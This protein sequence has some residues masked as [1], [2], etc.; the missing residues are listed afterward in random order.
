M[1]NR[2]INI[3]L[4]LAVVFGFTACETVDFG[5]T[6][7][8]P[9]N[10]AQP[11]P[12]GL[13]TSAER[14]LSGTIAATVP[15]MYVQYISNGQYPDESRYSG[16]NFGWAGYYGNL[17]DLQYVMENGTANQQ[18][19]ATL[20]RVYVLEKMTTRWGRI[21][22][23]EALQGIENIY[24]AYDS[25]ESIYTGLFNEIDN[26]LALIDHS[27]PG[28]SGDFLFGG[29][30]QRW[31]DFG[32]TL[33]LIMGLRLS[34]AAPSMGMDKFN[35]ALGNAISSNA[36]NFIYPYLPEESND[37]PWEDRFET[38]IDYLV[39]DTFVDP[40]IGSGT[41]TA[42]EDPRLW[43]MAQP[44]LTSGEFVGAPYGE[45]NSDTDA[46]SFI[47]DDIINTQDAP[48]YIFHYSE[49]LFAR[50][51]A[52]ALGWTSED[53]SELY[54]EAIAASMDQWGVDEADAQA[55]IAANPYAGLESI[56]YEKWVAMYLMAYESWAEW[57]RME[58]MGYEKELTP[59]E[60]MLSNATGIPDRQAY[61]TTARPQNEESYDAAIQAQG[62]DELNTKI[63]LF[64]N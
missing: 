62:P 11:S 37:N 35:E 4:I 42:P 63:W 40:L 22:Y 46:F 32:H 47:T 5:D 23:T 10:P 13:L 43:E 36:G 55:Y 12:A 59:P 33:K 48:L 8:N 16:L 19:A 38:R 9:N 21:P 60:V 64:E 7:V 58:A 39:S 28:P 30:T 15:N 20:L 54:E 3:S 14:S 57:R 45:Q 1:K 51:E 31:E 27:A 41:A 18:A 26:A 17:N 34:N 49:V 50:A 2:L 56:G 6:N 61:S 24:P 52:A 29:S 44:A 25:Q 53:P